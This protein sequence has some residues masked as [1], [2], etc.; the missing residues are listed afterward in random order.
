MPV[1]IGPL[2]PRASTEA[3]RWIRKADIFPSES[4][5]YSAIS[6]GG[7]MRSFGR[8]CQLSPQT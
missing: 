7:G 4:N 5:R 1:D 8:S 2:L 6:R 3:I